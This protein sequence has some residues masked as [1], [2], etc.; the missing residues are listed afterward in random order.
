MSYYKIK[1]LVLTIDDHKVIDTVKWCKMP[2]KACWLTP[3]VPKTLSF[4]CN[5]FIPTRGGVC[6]QTSSPDVARV[7]EDIGPLIQELQEYQKQIDL[8]LT[9][10]TTAEFDVLEAQ[11]N[12]ALTDLR[13]MR[14]QAK[15]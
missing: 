2:S 15:S 7:H 1:D 3:S 10:K 13:S 9:P 11:L 8:E 5:D 6:R 14:K 4:Y 12:D